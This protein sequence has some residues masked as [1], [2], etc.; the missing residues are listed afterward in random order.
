MIYHI[1]NFYKFVKYA[2]YSALVHLVALIFCVAV[3]PVS[4]TFLNIS[5]L[6]SCYF[7]VLSAYYS[8]HYV[9]GYAIFCYMKRIGYFHAVNTYS[10]KPLFWFDVSFNNWYEMLGI[11]LRKISKRKKEK[12]KNDYI[13]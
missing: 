1:K 11:V 3:F 12:G 2:N 7:V 6:F 5:Q 10:E 8:F 4:L 13:I 9:V